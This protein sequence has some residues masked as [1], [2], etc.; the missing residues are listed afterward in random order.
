MTSG[1]RSKKNRGRGREAIDAHRR[2]GKRLVAP[3]NQLPLR[4][5]GWLRDLLPDMLWL[6]FQLTVDS[7]AGLAAIARVLDVMGDVID[8]HAPDDQ[9]VL[10]GRLST[11][12]AVPLGVRSNVLQALHASGLYG[13]AVPEQFVDALAVYSDVPGAWL[14]GPR[15]DRMPA[16]HD[17]AQAALEPVVVASWHGQDLIPTR[18]KFMVLRAFA[19]AGKIKIPAGGPQDF[20]DALAR[21]PSGI[22]E[23][24]RRWVEPTIR[25]TFGAFTA[26]AD[27][28][29]TDW[30]S[31]FW[32]T[33]WTLFQCRRGEPVEPANREIV[34]AAREEFMSAAQ[35]LSERF[36]R[37]AVATDPDLY[38]PDRYEV[39][40]GIGARA[41][42]MGFAVASTPALWSTGLG[43]PILRATAESLITIRWLANREA[44]DPS[45]YRQFKE[46]G[47]GQLKL[48]KLHVEEY[49]DGLASVPDELQEFLRGV[50]REVN[51][52]IM[53]WVQDIQVGGSFSNL[54]MRKM[55]T[56]VG[57]E[58]MYRLVFQPASSATHGEWPVIDRSVL[59]RCLNPLHG[60]HRI[61]R[62][63]L[64][65]ALSP[66]Y[67]AL[68]LSLADD[69]VAAYE[70]A[71]G[72]I[73]TKPSG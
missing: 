15:L 29:S 69:V 70:A 67:A 30:P 72:E 50:E 23:D 41:V 57:L 7:T 60:A 6:C 11:F 39:L 66:E 45:V 62:V 21:Y 22:S 38:D 61:P 32:R 8:E 42:Q 20:V 17:R 44:G 43:S 14:I 68:S 12:E 52:D 10:D 65:Q 5:I 58:A 71:A 1:R 27:R 64:G 19:M 26:A 18:A 49:I 53:E 33:N 3:M 36:R 51:E 24:E 47:R 9:I 46:Y 40:T 48:F 2:V 13:V 16:N 55:A 56:E 25:A 73:V 31:R 54:D 34:Q 59:E 63:D 37:A 35:Q 28:K 4:S